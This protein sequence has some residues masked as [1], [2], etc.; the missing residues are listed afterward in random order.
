M[1]VALCL[2]RQQT[3][4]VAFDD[5]DDVVAAAAGVV[6]D[7]VVDAADAIVGAVNADACVVALPH[8]VVPV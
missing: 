7:D 3:L 6:V 2:E 8:D 4:A 5:G 1:A